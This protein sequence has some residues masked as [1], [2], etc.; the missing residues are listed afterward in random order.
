MRHGAL[1]LAQDL[2]TDYGS[3]L[4]VYDG[5]ILVEQ[6][7]AISRSIP[8]PHHQLYFATVTNGNV[9]LLK[10]FLDRG[11][12]IHGN[13]PGDI[14]LA[15]KAGFT[16]DRIIYS[17]SNLS[18][19]DFYQLLDWGI[20]QLNLDSISQVESFINVYQQHPTFSHDFTPKIGLRLNDPELTGNS[21]IGVQP[22]EFDRGIALLKQVNLKLTGLHFY[23]GTGTNSTRAFTEVIQAII[24][25]GKMLPDWQ[26][27]DFGGGFGYNYYH[28]NNNF[29]W[30]EF[31]E[32][33]NRQLSSLDR[34]IKLIL[35][36]GRA[37]IANCGIL[38]TK[39]VSTK[40]QGNKQIVGTDT[41]IANLT[42][43]AVYGN[44][45]EIISLKQSTIYHPTDVCGNTTYS[46]DILGKNCQLPALEIGDILAVMDVGAYGY[47]M[48]SHFLHRPKPAEVL[49][50]NGDRSLIRKRQNYGDLWT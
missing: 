12:G 22:P 30:L 7:E 1:E 26:Y 35:E 49:I 8:Y 46:R 4:Y 19:D 48:S 2:L 36:P 6:I 29:D 38:L 44:Y 21:R 50:T 10:F 45:R 42:A 24:T 23:R 40:W 41:T 14:Y 28:G 31:G 13:S 27:L 32:E 47:A 18:F 16:S 3:P 34:P 15:L 17:G 9:H 25:I 5:D 43:P 39:I 33:L 37:V 20:Y 11:W